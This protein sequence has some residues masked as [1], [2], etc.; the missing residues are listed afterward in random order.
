LRIR[1]RS[2]RAGTG[3]E[4]FWPSFVDVMTSIALIM[5]FLMLLVYIQ[6]LITGNKLTTARNRL[7]E[8]EK[9]LAQFQI[10]ISEAKKELLLLEEEMEE[11]RKELALSKEMIEQQK[12]TIAMSNQELEEMR[13]QLEGIALLRVEVLEKVKKSI[14][15]ELGETDDQGQPLVTIGENA[16]IVINES[17]MFA[18]NSYDIKAEG[19]ALLKELATAFENILDTPDIVENIDAI[20]IEGHT[21]DV[22]SSAYNRDLSTK[23]A[24]A[25]VNYLMEV[26]PNLEKKYG[27]YFAATG[28]S[29]FRPIAEGTSN[30]AR[31]QNRRIEISIAIKDSNV[32]KVIDNYLEET[33]S[34]LNFSQ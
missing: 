6:N 10:E 29:E 1:V 9:R 19:K 27:R 11:T 21:D 8:A 20:I 25:V 18:Y 7:E 5:F 12:K 26:N 2:Y 23:R 32:R 13:A 14:E 33:K 34:L 16:N 15:S 30:E 22:G 4:N 31:R 3:D 28:Y 24:T 17:L